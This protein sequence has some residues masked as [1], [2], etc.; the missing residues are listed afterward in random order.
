MNMKIAT[1][2][3]ITCWLLTPITTFA[4]KDKGDVRP[5]DS[6][7]CSLLLAGKLL[8]FFTGCSGIGSE[9]EIVEIKAIDNNGNEFVKKFP[10][11]VKYTDITLKRGITSNIEVWDWRQLV[12]DGLIT[13]ARKNVTVVVYNQDSEEIAR[14]ELIKAWPSK[15]IGP[16]I[17]EGN[18]RG[19]EEITIVYESMYRSN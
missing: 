8:G 14:W 18:A 3:F 5:A 17:E 4:A 12:V 19:I 7:Q 2:A 11:L 13:E 10:G 6:A 15:V 1:V 16:G 9:S